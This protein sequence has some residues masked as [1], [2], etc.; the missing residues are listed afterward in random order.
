MLMIQHLGSTWSRPHSAS[1]RPMKDLIL[2]WTVFLKMTSTGTQAGVYVLTKVLWKRFY[3]IPVELSLRRERIGF[4]L[5][6]NKFYFCNLF[7]RIINFIVLYSI[8]KITY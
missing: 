4:I 1:S 3:I 8:K 2:K 5:S 7:Y 6:R